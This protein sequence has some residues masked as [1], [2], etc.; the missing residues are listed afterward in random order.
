MDNN[1]A[2]ARVTAEDSSHLKHRTAAEKQ[3]QD[4]K[5]VL[6]KLQKEGAEAK[7]NG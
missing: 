4:I 5:E 3:L 1:L 6:E 2:S 7:L